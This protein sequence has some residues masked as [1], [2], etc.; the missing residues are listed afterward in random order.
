MKMKLNECFI[1]SAHIH[2]KKIE[3]EN[4]ATE[5]TILKRDLLKTYKQPT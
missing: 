1:N 2:H 3:K 5:E 4:K